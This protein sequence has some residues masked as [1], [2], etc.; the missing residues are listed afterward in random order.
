MESTQ[1]TR[2]SL[3][4]AAEFLF[5]E[6]G[7]QATSLRAVTRRAG[8]NLAAVNYHF[9]SKDGLVREVFRRRLE[10]VNQERLRLLNLAEEAA[11]G[12]ELE[13]EEVLSA[14]FLP[15]L[16]LQSGGM[17]PETEAGPKTEAGSR[18]EAGTEADASSGRQDSAE[19]LR[20]LMGRTFSEPGL[21]MQ[22][23]MEGQFEVILRR[24]TAAL[25]R[26]L[27]HLSAPELLWRLHFM[28]GAVIQ[29]TL[30]GSMICQ[31]SEGRCDPQDVETL[32][33]VLVTYAAAGMR[34]PAALDEDLSLPPCLAADS[35]AAGSPAEGEA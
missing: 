16:R 13:L 9:G 23:L 4:D 14:F 8:A 30:N 21:E 31:V 34:A 20:R 17:G 29:V 6:K 18:T 15:V 2:D 24:F 3:L 22:R 35:P 5:A 25:H 7:I 12:S 32:Q 1:Q 28:V 27:P 33:R 26:C 19:T 11:E 10:P